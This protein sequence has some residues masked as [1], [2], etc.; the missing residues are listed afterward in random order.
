FF[1]SQLAFLA[2]FLDEMKVVDHLLV[3]RL[4]FLI[5]FLEDFRRRARISGKKEEEVIF[6]VDARR[7]GDLERPRF[8][9][10]VGMKFKTGNAS[11]SGD[12]LILLANRFLKATQFDFT[13]LFGKVRWTYR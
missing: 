8:N 4:A 13:S 6:Q 1:K 11:V 2:Q 12:I 10:V 7:L 9:A 5:L 3:R